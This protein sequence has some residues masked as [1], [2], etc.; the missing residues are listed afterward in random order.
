MPRL[1]PT[2]DDWIAREAMPFSLDSPRTFDAAV[3]RLIGSLDDSVEPLGL[4]EA[5]HGGADIL[6]LR[7]R[8]FQRLV[9]AHGYS[10]IAI[11]SSFPRTRPVDDYV[12]GR[13]PGSYED[14]QEAGFSY[15]LG[16]LRANRE[17]VKWMRRYSADPS[18]PVKLRGQDS[19]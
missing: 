8:L 5:L 14:V 3:D 15:G 4:G 10:A 7:H 11:E 17:L 12:A 1:H 9:E 18:H 16:R 2:L 6:A 19:A 13:G